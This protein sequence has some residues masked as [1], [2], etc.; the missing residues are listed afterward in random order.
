MGVCMKINAF[1]SNLCKAC[2]C[3]CSVLSDRS[4]ASVTAQ[5]QVTF[6]KPAADTTLD[7]KASIVDETTGITRTQM[8]GIHSFCSTLVVFLGIKE[9]LWLFPYLQ[10]LTNILL[11]TRIQIPTHSSIFAIQHFYL[12]YSWFLVQMKMSMIKIIHFLF[13]FYQTYTMPNL[14]YASMK[15]LCCQNSAKLFACSTKMAT[16]QLLRRSSAALCEALDNSPGLKNF[17]ICFRRSIVMV[18]YIY[19]FN[20]APN[21]LT[22]RRDSL[23]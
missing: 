10:P 9:R 2:F 5:R 4:T 18:C 17:R 7:R 22:A 8:K 13:N 1:V 11:I 3:P 21:I 16:E 6:L 14:L 20:T 23:I 19:T 15:G 12:L